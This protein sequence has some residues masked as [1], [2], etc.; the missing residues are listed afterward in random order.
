V[1]PP[2]GWPGGGERVTEGGEAEKVS[3]LRATVKAAGDRPSCGDRS[4]LRLIARPV[5][6]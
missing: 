6:T 1:A 3:E 5:T 2:R 4:R